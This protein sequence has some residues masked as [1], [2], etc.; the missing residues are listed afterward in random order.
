MAG[1]IQLL[2][3]TLIYN[4]CL[5]CGSKSVEEAVLQLEVPQP[6]RATCPDWL[7]EVLLSLSPSLPFLVCLFLLHCRGPRPTLFSRLSADLVR[8]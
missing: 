8:S 2:A 7:Q 4:G 1:D 5:Q 3:N 6:L